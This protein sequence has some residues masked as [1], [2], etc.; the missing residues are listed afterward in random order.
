MDEEVE[1]G[2]EDSDGK[3][4]EFP[5]YFIEPTSLRNMVRKWT[6]RPLPGAVRAGVSSDGLGKAP[7]FSHTLLTQR[8]RI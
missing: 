3:G 5:P 1:E 8:H 6:F 2:Q 4:N 7:V